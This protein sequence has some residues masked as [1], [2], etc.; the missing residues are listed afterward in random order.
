MLEQLKNAAEHISEINSKTREEALKVRKSEIIVN[1]ALEKNIVN[2][3]EGKK[4]E[5]KIAAVDGGLL[6]QEMHGVDLIIARG[7]AAIFNYENSKLKNSEYYPDP[8]PKPEYTVEIGLDEHE[9]N[10]FRSL[11]RLGVE[12]N[13]AI[14][15]IEQF[16]PDV[17]MLDGALVPLTSDRPQE[18]SEVFAKYREVIL[19]YKKL[20]ALCEEKNCLLLGIIKDSRGRRFMDSIRG[21]TPMRS[22]DTVFLNHLLKEKE[23]SFVLRMSNEPKKHLILRDLDEWSGKLNLFYLKS[24]EGDRPMRI[25]FLNNT[26]NFDEIASLVYSLSAINQSYAY[27]AVLIEADLRAMLDP[28]EME[29]MQ[30][31]LQMLSSNDILP[32]RRNSRPFR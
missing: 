26:A 28:K 31:T 14:N 13:T 17:L 27:P 4:I 12:L 10:A 9:I 18:G 3:V 21:L 5:G 15:T 16:N 23:R 22:A 11:Y 1:E 32:L 29:R 7:A 2:K 8:F 24:V 30:K 6:A 20:Y 25:E 19:K